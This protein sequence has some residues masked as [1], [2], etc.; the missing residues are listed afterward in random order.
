M[1]HSVLHAFAARISGRSESN[2][3]YKKTEHFQ[4][5]R[6]HSCRMRTARSLTVSHSIHWGGMCVPCMPAAMHAPTTHYPPPPPCMP[7]H[8]ACHL[9]CMPPPH[10]ACS[11]CHACLPATHAPC[12]ACPPSGQTDT[13]E[14][15]TFANFVCGR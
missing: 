12:H 7:H 6:M 8:H 15:I 14:N 3:M 1:K 5:T 13:C 11:P 9:P 10:H 2:K 4:I